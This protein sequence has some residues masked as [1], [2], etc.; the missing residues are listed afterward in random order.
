MLQI[1][2]TFKA[3]SLGT[4]I[5]IVLMLI[6]AGSSLQNFIVLPSLL[7]G[8]KHTLFPT[9]LIILP[10][11]IPIAFLYSAFSSNKFSNIL[12]I[13]IDSLLVISTLIGLIFSLTYEGGL[14]GPGGLGA[15]MF[16]VVGLL[17]FVAQFCVYEIVK[18]TTPPKSI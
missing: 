15:L 5:V 17:I 3:Y 18:K 7:S 16:L 14:S 8:G 4:K 13:V 1:N 9:L 11:L 10:P 2:S 12:I 6:W